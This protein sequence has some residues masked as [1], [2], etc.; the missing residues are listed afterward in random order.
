MKTFK[1]ICATVGTWAISSGTSI[2]SLLIACVWLFLVAE[3][4]GS[5]HPSWHLITEPVKSLSLAT[6][7]ALLIV[8]HDH[9]VTI[10]EVGFEVTRQT[11]AAV[12]QMMEHFVM[13]SLKA[14]LIQFHERLNFSKLFDDLKPGDE[15]LWLDTFCTLSEFIDKI[16]PAL[17]RGATI[18]MLVINPH[19]ETSKLR[20]QELKGSAYDADMFANEAHAFTK[21]IRAIVNA[22][23]STSNALEVVIY[24]D[25]PC[26]PAYI[27]LH[28][29]LPVRGYSGHF[30][31]KPSAF[32]THLEW[33]PVAGGVLE[34]ML[35]Y[36]EQKWA[37]HRPRQNEMRNLDVRGNGSRR[38][39]LP[40]GKRIA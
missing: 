31:T 30:F 2:A 40:K 17:D 22:T 36:F 14:G 18:R 37:T 33:H 29:G 1:R 25:L 6:I 3:I 12:K 5:R 7:P 16:R 24:D 11:E 39:G 26:V 38:R 10:R 28:D 9:K 8:F 34:Q 4:F 19:C 32:G 27:V 20:A 21:R 23:D 15:L 13:G 35:K